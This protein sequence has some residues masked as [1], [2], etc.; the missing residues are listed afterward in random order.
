MEEDSE[1]VRRA[2]C[3]EAQGLKQGVAEHRC[4]KAPDITSATKGAGVAFV[5]DEQLST[6]EWINWCRKSVSLTSLKECECLSDL[7]RPAWQE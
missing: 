6:G 7:A 2:M 1:E 4:C 3:P 5:S